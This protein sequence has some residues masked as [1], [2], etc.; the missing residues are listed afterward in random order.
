LFICFY[1]PQY[2][3]TRATKQYLLSAR[4]FSCS[5]PNK[6]SWHHYRLSSLGLA[7]MCNAGSVLSTTARAN[8]LLSLL[9]SHAPSHIYCLQCV[10]SVKQCVYSTNAPP[11][12][13]SN[14]ARSFAYSSTVVQQP[15]GATTASRLGNAT[16]GDP[17]ISVTAARDKLQLKKRYRRVKASSARAPR[18]A[19]C[20]GVCT[21]ITVKAQRLLRGQS[22]GS[23]Q[24]W[25]WRKEMGIAK[26]EVPNPQFA[27]SS[28]LHR[29]NASV[30]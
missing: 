24:Q 2:N 29:R 13:P 6:N 27:V 8:L 5:Q 22:L 19:S 28:W 11:F 9:D 7:C 26:L 25:K 15:S 10:Y 3:F 17:S 18:S 20:L 23:R 21:A 4:L 1:F 30:S 14:V 16:P 12:A